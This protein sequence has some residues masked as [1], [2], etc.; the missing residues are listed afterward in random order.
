MLSCLVLS[1]YQSKFIISTGWPG[2]KLPSGELIWLS[3]GNLL[4]SQVEGEL[5]E[6]HIAGDGANFGAETSDLVSKHAWGR[7]LDGVVPIV[8]IV[9]ERVREVKNRHL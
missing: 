4:G 9:T 8:V 1:S 7:D 3:L 5:V 2:K 6:I